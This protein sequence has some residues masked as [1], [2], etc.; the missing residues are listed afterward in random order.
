MT[1]RK[2]QRDDEVLLELEAFDDAGSA[3]GVAECTVNDEVRQYKVTVPGAI[4][5]D[6]VRAQLTK[7]RK[8]KASSRALT[9]KRP[10]MA[11]ISPRCSHAFRIAEDGPF[12]GGCGLQHM[13]YD[14]QLLAKQAWVESCLR[15]E[16]MEHLQVHSVRPSVRRWGYR[17]K[18]EYSCT[19]NRHGE[20]ALGLYPRGYRYE[21]MSLREC[22]LQSEVSSR[23]LVAAGDWIRKSGLEPFG[24]GRGDMPGFIRTMTI[25]E[26]KRTG[27]RMIELTTSGATSAQMHGTVVASQDVAAAFSAFIEQQGTVT[28]WHWTRHHA[29]KGVRTRFETVHMGGKPA[30]YEEL[31]ISGLQPLRFEVHPRAFFQPNTLQAEILYSEVHTAATANP[32]HKEDLGRVLDLYCGTGTIGLTLARR[33][34][35]VIGIE[36]NAEAVE[37]ARKNARDNAI[38][39]A[40]FHAG[41]AADVLGRLHYGRQNAIDLVIVDPPRNG[42][43][44][45]AVEQVVSIGAPTIVYVSCN[46]KSL[47]RNL[48]QFSILG[49]DAQDVQPVDMFPHTFHIENVVRLNR[50]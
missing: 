25:R 16:G 9:L 33:A 1:S 28:S 22:H 40:F 50:R 32:T 13:A 41:D 8:R 19:R 2:L 4:P 30:L 34:R 3:Y 37:N 10:S 11:R 29:T 48:G 38:E 7:V 21:V 24:F 5:G 39:N 14:A 6:Q 27:D 26:G 44:D 43:S 47:A 35:E 36:L 17:N 45:A 23:L 46:P 42:L 49:Y 20:V 31:H 12:C 18:M 15:H